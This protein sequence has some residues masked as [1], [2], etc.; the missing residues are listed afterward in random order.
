MNIFLIQYL[1]ELQRHFPP[2]K[3]PIQVFLGIFRI[4]LILTISSAI[5]SLITGVI[6]IVKYF[7]FRDSTILNLSLAFI[8]MGIGLLAEPIPVA[9][10]IVKA[11]PISNIL[12]VWIIS[13]I[14]QVT[15]FSIIIATYYKSLAKTIATPLIYGLIKLTHL[16]VIPYIILLILASFATATILSNYIIK[17]NI[18]NLV[19]FTGFLSLVISYFLFIISKLNIL[20]SIAG[21]VFRVVAYLIFLIIFIAPPE[22]KYEEK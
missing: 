7:K 21:E 16:Y 12:T 3:P 9:Y 20:L 15:G 8:F 11:K 5:F 22:T 2:I 18:G 6:L 19:V 17:R 14:L 10:L 4:D 13:S 1:M